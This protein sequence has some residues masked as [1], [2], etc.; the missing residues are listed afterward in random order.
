[1]GLLDDNSPSFRVPSFYKQKRE[2]EKKI[3]REL[4]RAEFISEYLKETGGGQV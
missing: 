1:M 3:G 4:S 2:I